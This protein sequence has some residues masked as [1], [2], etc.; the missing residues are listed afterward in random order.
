MGILLRWLGAFVLLAITYNPTPWNFVTWAQANFTTNLPITLLLGLI[1]ALGYLLYV[2]ATLRSI[3]VLGIV[4]LAALFALVLWVLYDWGMLSL[5][6]SA[7][8][9]WISILVLSVILG[10]GLSASIIWQRMSG[11]ATV[12]DIER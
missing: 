4:L 2:G 9:T 3:G 10:V 11:Q 6:N 8:N 7:L 1:L 5:G 12:D